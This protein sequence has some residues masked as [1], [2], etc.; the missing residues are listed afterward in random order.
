M[1]KLPVTIALSALLTFICN[2]TNAHILSSIDVDLNDDGR[3]DRAVL[4]ENG[5]DVDL[6][7][8]MSHRRPDGTFELKQEIDKPGAARH[9]TSEGHVAFLSTSNNNLVIN[10]QNSAI[11]RVHWRESVT[12]AY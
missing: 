3:P 11:G 4:T 12:V 6:V 10:S 9:F 1:K 8:Y 5:E 7:I 2:V